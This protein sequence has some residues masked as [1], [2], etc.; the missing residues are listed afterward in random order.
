MIRKPI[1]SKLRVFWS[2]VD[3][4]YVA[5]VGILPGVRG[6]GKTVEIALLKLS[7]NMQDY[8]VRLIDEGN[9]I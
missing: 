4:E 9:N 6:T 1:N 5:M 2:K 3:G 7:I 8:V